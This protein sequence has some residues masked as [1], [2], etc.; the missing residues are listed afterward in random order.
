MV[1]RRKKKTEE[2]PVFDAIRKPTAPPTQRFGSGT[3]PEEKLHPTG[4]K[5]KHKQELPEDE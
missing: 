3:R 1:K 4:R 2:R 5:A